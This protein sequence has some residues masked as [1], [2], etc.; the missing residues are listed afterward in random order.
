MQGKPSRPATEDLLR[1]KREGITTTAIAE[2]LGVDRGT[3]QNWYAK[4]GM[5]AAHA[6]YVTRRKI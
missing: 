6:K 1:F 3:V 2:R 5:K 4:M